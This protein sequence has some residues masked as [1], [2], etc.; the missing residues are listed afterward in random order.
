MNTNGRSMFDVQAAVPAAISDPSQATRLPL[1]LLGS[2]RALGC[3]FRR[4]RR[5]ISLRPERVL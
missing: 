5:N 1:Q 2:A 3:W 4:H